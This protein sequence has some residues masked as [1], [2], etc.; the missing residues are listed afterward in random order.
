ML[1]GLRATGRALGGVQVERRMALAAA[2]GG[3]R[4][5]PVDDVIK[6]AGLWDGGVLPVGAELSWRLEVKT[7]RLHGWL[8]GRR[9]SVGSRGK[10]AQ[11]GLLRPLWFGILVEAVEHDELVFLPV[12]GFGVGGTLGWRGARGLQ[13]AGI[14]AA[15]GLR[16]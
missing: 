1:R 2:A 3:A 16:G 15:T 7:L 6:P 10:A 14:L 4:Q 12:A 8:A 5:G 9:G 13:D 11:F